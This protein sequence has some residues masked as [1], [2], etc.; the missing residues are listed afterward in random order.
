VCCILIEIAHFC[1]SVKKTLIVVLG[2]TASG[3]T[4]LSIELAKKYGTEIV[5]ADSRQVFKEMKIGTARPD[6]SETAG[7]PH[8]LLGHVSIHDPY[9]AG[10][11]EEE[12]VAIIERLF[13]KHNVVVV[14]GG[15]G[16]YI[17]ALLEG[18]DDVPQRNE[19][20][21]NELIAI[22]E[23][24]GIESLQNMLRE[25]DPDHC[26]EIDMQNPQRLIRAIEMVKTSGKTHRELRKGLR[27]ERPWRTVKFGIKMDREELYRRI[28][29]RVDHMM[30][31][32]L[33]EEAKSLYPNR[34][35]NALQTV[36]YS[37]LFDFFDGKTTLEQAAELIKQHTRNYAKR[38]LTWF[39]RD[40]EI[41]WINPGTVPNLP[42]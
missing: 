3:K 13:I 19:S 42:V 36:G 1:L 9:N 10:K 15:T 12:A 37:E 28:N 41:S 4:A 16:L 14:C 26:G 5:S 24:K 30:E 39:R 29:L 27:K 21:R 17:N 20:L 22:Y 35:L 18:F 2:P 34:H 40:E 23:T 33:L 32:G 31:A 8:H 11:F 25:I 38:Q 6:A 7:I